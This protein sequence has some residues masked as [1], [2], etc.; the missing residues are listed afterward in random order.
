MPTASPSKAFKM[1]MGSGGCT[2]AKQ[3]VWMI[4]SYPYRHLGNV[5]AQTTVCWW[6]FNN[7]LSQRGE[8]KVLGF[9]I[10][11]FLW[12]KTFTPADVKLPTGHQWT[13]C[14]NKMLEQDVR[15][16]FSQLVW[17]SSSTPLRR[18]RRLTSQGE[19]CQRICSHFVLVSTFYS[20]D[21]Y[22]L[23]SCDS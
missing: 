3:T 6:V 14:W 1:R 9:S 23:H 8:K 17:A 12:C 20:L 10:C 11:Q 15:N 22:Y 19:R 4:H 5:S 13:R 7:Q 21:I 16:R 2:R 18:R